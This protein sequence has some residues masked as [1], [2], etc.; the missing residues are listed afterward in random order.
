[1]TDRARRDRQAKSDKFAALKLAR[2]GGRREW[3]VR[4]GSSRIRV[5][6]RRLHA[7]NTSFCVPREK[8]QTYMTRSRRINTRASSKVV[9]P[10]T[11]SLLTMVLGA[12]STTAWT[13]GKTS[14]PKKTQRTRP[15]TEPVRY[16]IAH[17]FPSEFTTSRRRKPRRRRRRANPS[18]RHR[19]KASLRP[20]QQ[21]HSVPIVRLC[22][23]SR[24]MPSYQGF[25]TAGM[26]LRYS[27]TSK[28]VLDQESGNRLQVIAMMIAL[29]HLGH[30]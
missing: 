1:M 30:P 26:T 22:R 18:P 8:R 20:Q 27:L 16:S 5:G 13:I 23:R 11:T 7:A 3:K 10:R 17:A 6:S 9:W 14:A 4:H 29:H 15:C 21:L 28:R 25:S 12:T 24:R 2:Q 19:Q